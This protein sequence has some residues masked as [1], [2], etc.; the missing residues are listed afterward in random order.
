V[1]HHCLKYLHHC[2]IRSPCSLWFH[3]AVVWAKNILWVRSCVCLPRFPKTVSPEVIVLFNVVIR[4]VKLIVIVNPIVIN[5]VIM[6]SLHEVHGRTH[7]GLVRPSVFPHDSTRE[8]MDGLIWSSV[9]VLCHSGLPHIHN[10]QYPTTGDNK[11]ADEESREVDRQSLHLNFEFGNFEYGKW[12]FWILKF[13]K[14]LK[15]LNYGCFKNLEFLRIFN[16]WE[17][18][19]LKIFKSW[20]IEF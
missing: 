7:Y 15:V 17:F 20:K 16:F 3:H 9:W 11:L 6:R 14:I 5:I 1:I 19:V 8:P 18:E 2:F 13:R 4:I 10:F 12:K